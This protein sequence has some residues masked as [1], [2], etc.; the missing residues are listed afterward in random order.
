VIVYTRI[1]ATA[2][3]WNLGRPQLVMKASGFP[4]YRCNAARLRVFPSRGPDRLV[5]FDPLVHFPSSVRHEQ[6]SVA[7]FTCV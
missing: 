7:V 2:L 6:M 5:C 1:L 4:L 3:Q